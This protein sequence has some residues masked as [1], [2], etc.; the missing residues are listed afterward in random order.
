[1]N[2]ELTALS[3]S[4][5]ERLAHIDFTLMFNGEAGRSYLTE[6][7]NVAP[8]VATQD[9]ARYKELAPNNVQYDEKRRLHLKTAEFKPLFE[10]DAIRTLATISQGF[11]DGFLGKL[12]APLACEAPY[13][14]NKPSLSIVSA[15]SEAIHKRAPLKITYVSLSS[16]QGERIIVPHTLV[17]NGLR[18]HIRAYDRKQGAFRDFVLTRI[19]DAHLIEAN[20]SAGQVNEEQERIQQDKQ[21]NRI[22]DLELIPHPQ[23]KHPEA[24]ALDYG[25]RDGCLKVEIRAAVTG[26]LLRLWNVDCSSDHRLST[27]EIQLA[28]RNPAALY[29]VEN[30]MLAPGVSKA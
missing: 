1:M 21:W 13:H 7:F 20:V 18:W 14:L 30:A 4:Q 19:K 22:V 29:G 10:Y 25:M 8:S 12:K 28:L 9:F 3:H 6:R 26:Y 15:I 17:D 11:G 23:L 16:G 24:V 2:S 27:P 5:K